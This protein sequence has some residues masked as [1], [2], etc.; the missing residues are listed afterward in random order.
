[1][2]KMDRIGA[3]FYS[4][5]QSIIDRL[6]ANPVPIQVPIGRESDFRGSVDLISMKGY[7]YDDETLGAKYKIGEIPVDM[8]DQANEYR[9]K[10]SMQWLNLMI[11]LW[12]ST[13]TV[14]R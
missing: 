14:N 2:N 6:G 8:V 12:R 9:Q 1:M 4:S 13:L 5:V 10:C 7:F 3:D 11:R